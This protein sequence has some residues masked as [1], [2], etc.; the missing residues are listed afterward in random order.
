MS[1][2]F[3]TII[4]CHQIGQ[5]LVICIILI[6]LHLDLPYAHSRMV[7]MSLEM[8]LPTRPLQSPTN[9]PGLKWA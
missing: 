9:L 4:C 1:I 3:S 8:W 6:C 2:L 5:V 7:S